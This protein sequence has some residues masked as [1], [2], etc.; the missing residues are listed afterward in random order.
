[1]R[2][3]PGEANRGDRAMREMR[4][5]RAAAH[6]EIVQAGHANNGLIPEGL[7]CAKVGCWKGEGRQGSGDIGQ[8]ELRRRGAGLHSPERTSFCNLRI[9][10]SLIQ[11]RLQI[12]R[13][14]TS[15]QLSQAAVG[16]C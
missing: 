13:C 11:T 1:M 5:I 4:C 8:E 9:S 14:S 2:H 15:D 10:A 6:H 7:Q 12:I 3:P 16:E